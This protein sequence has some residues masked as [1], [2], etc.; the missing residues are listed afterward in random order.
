MAAASARLTREPGS[1]FAQKE[2]EEEEEEEGN[3]EEE[4]TDMRHRTKAK[5][6]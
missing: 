6:R 4:D 5:G 2:E 1:A 3:E